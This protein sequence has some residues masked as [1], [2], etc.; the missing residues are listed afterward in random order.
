[1]KWIY[2]SFLI[3]RSMQFLLAI[4]GRM[5]IAVHNVDDRQTR[6]HEEDENTNTRFQQSNK[7]FTTT[8]SKKVYDGTFTKDTGF[9]RVIQVLA[10]GIRNV[11]TK[12]TMRGCHQMGEVCT[13]HD[14]VVGECNKVR[15]GMPRI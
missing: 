13:M 2:Y 5:T 6:H 9:F 3:P 4:M 10:Q 1:M 12:K 7:R 11:L 14:G 15:C 8:C